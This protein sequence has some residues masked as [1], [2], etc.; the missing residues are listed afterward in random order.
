MA[1]EVHLHQFIKE[2]L[3]KDGHYMNHLAKEYEGLLP[4]L[5]FELTEGTHSTTV[6]SIAEKLFVERD[7]TYPYVTSLL[8]FSLTLDEYCKK[9]NWYETDLLI[10][11]LVN[12]LTKTSFNPPNRCVII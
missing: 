2:V 12:I 10:Q 9:Y 1:R 6:Q 11:I 4:Q 7:A 8:V 3:Q 5:D